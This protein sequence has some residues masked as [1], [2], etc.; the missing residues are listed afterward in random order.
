MHFAV[1]LEAIPHVYHG[2]GGITAYSVIRSLLQAEHKVSLVTF[3]SFVSSSGKSAQ[4]HVKHL[5]DLGVRV[6]ILSGQGQLA[7][8]S[9]LQK[10]FPRDEDLF[11]SLLQRKKIGNTLDSIKPDALFMYHWSPIAAAYGYHQVPKLGLVGDP[12]HLPQL[13]RKEF[14]RRHKYL[15]LSEV[16]TW[17]KDRTTMPKLIKWQSKLLLDCDLSGAFAAHHAELFR[18]LGV[19]NCHYF[20]TPTPNSV[21]SQISTPKPPKLK[22]LHI[23]H[24]QGIATL[25]GIELL[26]N[27]V[28]PYLEKYLSK[29][30][31]ECHI[32]GGHYESIPHNLKKGLEKPSVVVRGQ[33]TPADREF[34]TS[35]I[36]LVPTPIELG[37]RVRIITA[38]SHGSCVITHVA[39]T[40]GIPELK[41]DEN[42]LIG[43]TGEELGRLCI[44]I[45][46][47]P[48]RRERI[49]KNARRTYEDCFS[50]E[51]AGRAIVRGLEDLVN[52]VASKSEYRFA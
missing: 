35:H 32:V 22:I 31:F 37:I 16:K 40:K 19:R 44:E 12:A 45:A 14:L 7:P 42:S 2:G 46:N 4:E 30:S 6:E 49:E 50:L 13:F 10:F 52:G 15:P 47:D 38:L 8:L 27:E 23:G 9:V 11:P 43:R 51:T 21:S 1:V 5:K 39:N 3:D 24:L 33:V 25:S 41:H 28:L 17:I 20:R 36:I 48:S 34:Q 29:G 18:K 26:A